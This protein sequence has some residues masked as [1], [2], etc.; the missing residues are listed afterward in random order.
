MVKKRQNSIVI[1][2]T[3]RYHSATTHAWLKHSHQ[4][5]GGYGQVETAT[6]RG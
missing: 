4:P 2:K 6:Y 1:S 5:L 3:A